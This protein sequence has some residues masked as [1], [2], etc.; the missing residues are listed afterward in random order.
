MN[1]LDDIAIATVV[2]RTYMHSMNE[3]GHAACLHVCIAVLH[4][5]RPL[6]HWM[7]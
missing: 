5:S 4:L 7:Q 3:C 2:S 1:S 6:F